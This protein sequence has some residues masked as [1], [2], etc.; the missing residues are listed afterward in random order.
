MRHR[1]FHLLASPL[2]WAAVVLALVQAWQ[3]PLTDQQGWQQA[4]GSAVTQPAVHAAPA[5]AAALS[6]AGLWSLADVLSEE[7]EWPQ[8]TWLAVRAHGLRGPLLAAATPVWPFRGPDALLR[9]P[10]ALPCV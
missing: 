9:P 7:P 6:D 4:T 2:L 3:T 5:T 10:T 8:A 1:F